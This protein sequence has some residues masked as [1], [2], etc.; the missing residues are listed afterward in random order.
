MKKYLFLII[1]TFYLTILS[2]GQGMG[3]GVSGI[4]NFQTKSIGFGARFNL[5]PS[6]G[7]RLIPQFAYYPGFNNINEY[8]AGLGFEINVY[9]IK[10]FNFYGLLHFG[11]NHW[12]NSSLSKMEKAG[13]DNW[14]GELGIGVVTRKGCWR[15]FTEFRYNIRW[16]ETNF[17]IGIM[18]VFKCKDKGYGAVNKRRSRPISC[19]AYN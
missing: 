13:P 6:N 18:Y 14:V 11:Y 4:Y 2:H 17:R 10:K 19:P 12:I 1:I 16:Y 7:F 5:K 15:P 3:V 8:Y 9:K